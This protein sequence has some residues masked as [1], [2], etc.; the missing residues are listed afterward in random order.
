MMAL[1]P[2][3]VDENWMVLGGNMRL[4]ALQDLGYTQLSEN[5]VIK[6]S[7]LTEEQKQQFIIKDNVGFGDWDWDMLANEWDAEELEHWGLDLPTE[8]GGEDVEQG[9]QD[10]PNDLWTWE[11]QF[12]DSDEFNG[13]LSFMGSA[14]ITFDSASIKHSAPNK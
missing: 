1:R 14:K 11:I 10:S 2:I 9:G 6:A 12:T 7:D 13:F 5:W 8:W 4:N 3:V